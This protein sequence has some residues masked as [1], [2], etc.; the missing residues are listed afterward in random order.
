MGNNCCSDSPPVLHHTPS[1]LPSDSLYQRKLSMFA[2][3]FFLE[4]NFHRLKNRDFSLYFFKQKIVCQFFIARLE[5]L[6]STKNSSE[7][8]VT[9]DNR[10]Y[11]TEIKE[12][13][14]IENLFDEEREKYYLMMGLN[15]EEVVKEWLELGNQR[16]KK[17]KF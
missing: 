11:L 7:D 5:N 14:E 17:T 9:A 4:S 10:D 15:E 16:L 12:Y 3:K 6:K 8:D 2:D 13:L 1:N